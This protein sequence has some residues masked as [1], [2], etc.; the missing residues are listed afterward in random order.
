VRELDNWFKSVDHPSKASRKERVNAAVE[1][2]MLTAPAGATDESIKMAASLFLRES[3]F[4]NDQYDKWSSNLRKGNNGFNM[5]GA[6]TSGMRN[7]NDRETING[8]DTRRVSGFGTYNTI[9]ENFDTFWQWMSTKNNYKG[10]T[11]I[12]SKMEGLEV[13]SRSG[14]AT[15]MGSMDKIRQAAQSGNQ[16]VFAPTDKDSLLYELAWVSGVFQ[17]R[18]WDIDGAF[19][20]AKQRH[21]G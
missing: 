1:M 8:Q 5:K 18:A 16:G 7:V 3:G 21:R 12:N 9:S 14:W 11:S 13:L 15:D 2:A 20:A 6:G 19:N 17:G 4:A 10:F